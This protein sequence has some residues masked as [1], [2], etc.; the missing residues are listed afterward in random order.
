MRKLVLLEVYIKLTCLHLVQL[1]WLTEDSDTVS[2]LLANQAAM[3][4]YISIES[5]CQ[6]TPFK[7]LKCKFQFCGEYSN[8]SK[9]IKQGRRCFEAKYGV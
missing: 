7:M 1:L 9:F 2:I 3:Q 5:F 4:F 8:E 6:Q